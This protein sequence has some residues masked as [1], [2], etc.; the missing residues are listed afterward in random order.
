LATVIAADG[1]RAEVLAKAALLRGFADAFTIIEGSGAEAL[2]VDTC[3]RTRATEG[4]AAFTGGQPIAS[5][6]SKIEKELFS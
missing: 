6:Q 2:V 4:F 1:W 3:G 5:H